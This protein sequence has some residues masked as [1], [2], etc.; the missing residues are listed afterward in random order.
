MSYHAIGKD[1]W[2]ELPNIFLD[3]ELAE[4]LEGGERF[5]AYSY[6]FPSTAQP[7]ATCHMEAGISYSKL[8]GLFTKYVKSEG[9]I[10][11]GA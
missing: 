4:T 8:T 10:R 9:V 1:R 6:M 7:G 2:E 3:T 5:W 11:D